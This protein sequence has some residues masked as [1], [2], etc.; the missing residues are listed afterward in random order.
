M[1]SENV[2][3]HAFLFSPWS[4]MKLTP[5]ETLDKTCF[6]LKNGTNEK[7]SWEKLM[8]TKPHRPTD[9]SSYPEYFHLRIFSCWEK[10]DKVKSICLVSDEDEPTGGWSDER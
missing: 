5:S 6:F 2:E 3:T 8:R 4:E 9:A 10:V 7:N 1:Q